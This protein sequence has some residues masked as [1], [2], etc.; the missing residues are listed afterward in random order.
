MNY[1]GHVSFLGVPLP[2][3]AAALNFHFPQTV[4]VGY[5]YRPTTN[6]NLEA[7]A[8]WTDWSSLRAAPIQS[9]PVH[10]GALLFNWKPSTLYEFGVTRYLGQGWRASAGYMYSE[11]SVPNSA[12]NA[13]IADSDRHLFSLGIGKTCK[14]FSWDA[15]YQLGVG[16]SRSVSGDTTG[17]YNGSYEFFSNALSIN[18]GW[19]F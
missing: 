12:F 15:A 4:V 6:W 5:S 2:A 18:I 7:D 3:Q 11:N 10:P 14:R 13:L 17:P 8:D 19:H 1:Q 9:A 16:P